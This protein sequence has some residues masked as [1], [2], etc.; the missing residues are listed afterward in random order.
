M[1]DI[2]FKRNCFFILTFFSIS[3]F[4]VGVLINNLY[5]VISGA[6]SLTFCGFGFII[7]CLMYLKRDLEEYIFRTGFTLK[8]GETFYEHFKQLNKVIKSKKGGK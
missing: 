4:F 1:N 7:I 3:F 8:L 6:L 2:N 5:W